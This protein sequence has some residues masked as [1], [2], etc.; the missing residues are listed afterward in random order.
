MN[1]TEQDIAA[2]IKELQKKYFLIEKNPKF[3]DMPPHLQTVEERNARHIYLIEQVINIVG[4]HFGLTPEQ[5]KKRTNASPNKQ[6][7]YTTPQIRSIVIKIAYA[8]P[9]TMTQ[10]IIGKVLNLNHATVRYNWMKCKQYIDADILFKKDFE[11]IEASV[12]EALKK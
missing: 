3:N 1:L 5:I 8:L 12:K 9:D 10:G 7:G 11:Q 4:D 2:I 6:I